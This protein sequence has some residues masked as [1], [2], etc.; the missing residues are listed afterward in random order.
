MSDENCETST[1]SILGS[2]MWNIRTKMPTSGQMLLPTGNCG[3]LYTDEGI[4]IEGALDST[5]WRVNNSVL[6]QVCN[7]L[8]KLKQIVM[9]SPECTSVSVLRKVEVPEQIYTEEW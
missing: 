1:S 9:E 8:P 6:V 2:V 5:P 7:R 3:I 4:P